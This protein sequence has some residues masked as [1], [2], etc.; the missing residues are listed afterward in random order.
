MPFRGLLATHLVE[1]PVARMGAGPLLLLLAGA[2]SLSALAALAAAALP[3]GPAPG[4]GTDFCRLAGR[5][6]PSDAWDGWDDSWLPW[7]A[8]FMAAQITHCLSGACCSSG[9]WPAQP[10]NT[11]CIASA[12]MLSCMR[13]GRGCT[14]RRSTCSAILPC[15]LLSH[16]RLPCSYRCC[17]RL[18]YSCVAVL[19][20][21]L[22]LLAGLG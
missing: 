11:Q 3:G 1:S 19:S 17:S 8:P 21:L 5:W 15:H 20:E 9:K 2:S 14:E 22:D 10:Q 4:P 16:C 7:L 13:R 6:S 18:G 12:Q